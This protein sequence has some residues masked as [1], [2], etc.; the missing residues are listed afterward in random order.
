MPLTAHSY[1][2]PN[3]FWFY[4]AVCDFLE[5][6]TGIQ[7]VLKQSPYDP[8]DDPELNA[9]EVNLSFICG[10]PLIRMSRTVPGLLHPLVA[11]V[12]DDPRAEGRPVYFADVIVRADSGFDSLASLEGST[13]CYNEINS[14][15]GHHL[16]RYHMLKNG[17][18]GHFFNRAITS[19]SHQQSIRRVLDGD[20]NCAA[21][22]STVL[23]Q[24][25]RD[26]PELKEQLRVVASTEP[27]PVPPL[28]MIE[29]DAHHRQTL[30]SVLADP[31]HDLS[32]AMQR[33]G[34]L[35]LV[36]VDTDDYRV[37]GEMYDQANA[38]DYHIIQ[39]PV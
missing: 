30:Q 35:T 13:F 15:S 5:R 36:P 32:H 12:V 4:Q 26:T 29:S 19:G 27:S 18:S 24:S 38:A 16:L 2:A 14:N 3:M 28:A 6:K 22:D 25:F 34:I 37:I 31:D 9:G 11:P 17:C 10:L 8:L 39:P 1:L 21:I 33:A 23:A 20:A 7:I